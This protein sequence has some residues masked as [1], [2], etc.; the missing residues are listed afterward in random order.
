M[1]REER[2]EMERR[3]VDKIQV[4]PSG[5][6]QLIYDCGRCKKK[7]HLHGGGSYEEL[8][9]RLKNDPEELNFGSR[10]SHCEKD[11]TR[12]YELIYL[13]GQTKFVS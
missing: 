11:T 13:K 1:G 6:I 3:I 2:K 8:K 9:K 10:V 5:N 12:D 4:N 7:I